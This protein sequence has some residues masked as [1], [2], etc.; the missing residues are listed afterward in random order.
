MFSSKQDEVVL[1]RWC[2]VCTFEGMS[3][4]H[5]NDGTD[6]FYCWHNHR[7]DCGTNEH[8]KKQTYEI[9]KVEISDIYMYFRRE[10]R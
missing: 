9:N 6:I 4:Q 8:Q 5:P 1:N 3:D 10:S 7:C 2:C